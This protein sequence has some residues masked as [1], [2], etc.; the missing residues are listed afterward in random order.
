MGRTAVDRV[1]AA[2][3]GGADSRSRPGAGGDPD[4]GCDA[5]RLVA[6]V[7]S[8]R[9]VQ[10]RA[11]AHADQGADDGTFSFGT[12][13]SRSVRTEIPEPEKLAKMPSIR[14]RS[15]WI[16]PIRAPDFSVPRLFQSGSSRATAE[17]EKTAARAT[18]AI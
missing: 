15:D 9:P 2:S 14:F 10:Y 4:A 8:D 3:G 5:M 1:L 16:I 11:T 17:T 12:V 7:L 13:I 18:A 6:Q